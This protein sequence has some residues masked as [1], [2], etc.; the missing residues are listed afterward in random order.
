MT[1]KPGDFVSVGRLTGLRE[2][3]GV[4]VRVCGRDLALFR[5][6]G[7]L[8][9]I[10]DR[11]PHQDAS[12]A[13]GELDGHEVLCP[14]HCWAFDLRTGERMDAPTGHRVRTYA[15]KQQGDEVLVALPEER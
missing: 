9:A 15:T 13:E 7:E 10:D 11:C 2:G 3:E 4:C 14:L 5:V 1:E 8:F 6:A 12:L